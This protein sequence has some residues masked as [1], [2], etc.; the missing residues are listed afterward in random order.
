MITTGQTDQQSPLPT[1]AIHLF[2]YQ[3]EK[4]DVGTVYH[5]LKSNIDRTSPARVFLFIASKTHLEVL[6]IEQGSELL[7]YVTADMDWAIFS[8]DHL[9]GWH[10][11]PDD[12]WAGQPVPPPGL[13]RSQALGALNHLGHTLTMWVSSL[14]GTARVGHYPVHIYNFDFLSFNFIFRHLI[15]PHASFEI[16]VIDPDPAVLRAIGNNEVGPEANIL[17]YRGK[18]CVAYLGDEPYRGVP[19]RKYRL[20]G[21]GMDD[22]DGFI[23]VNQAKGHFENIEHPLADNPSWTS[24]KLELQA[25]EHMQ[26]GEWQRYIAKERRHNTQ[27]VRGGVTT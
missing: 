1:S 21:P 26:A 24:F 16:G 18:A 4:I 27:L 19:C 13:L 9:E 2:R 7:A 8:A 10:I 17:T 20:N 14:T 6:K 11:L 5:Y 23:W 25:T 15:D 3:P 22:K 12:E